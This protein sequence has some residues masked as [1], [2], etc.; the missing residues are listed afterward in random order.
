MSVEASTR[1]GWKLVLASATGP[2]TTVPVGAG[3]NANVDLTISA[4]PAVIREI[5]GLKSISG[6]PD[7]IVLVGITYPDTSTVRIR[8]LNHSTSTVSITANSV[9]ASILC[10]AY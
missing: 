1:E 8:V 4:N 3:A 10:K 5:L 2:S 7:G 6:L 9:S